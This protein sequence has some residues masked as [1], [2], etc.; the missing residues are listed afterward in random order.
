M[1]NPLYVGIL[2][3]SISNNEP[4]R[5]SF[6]NGCGVKLKVGREEY[7]YFCE[8]CFNGSSVEKLLVQLSKV[9]RSNSKLS[10]FNGLLMEKCFMGGIDISDISKLVSEV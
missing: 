2:Y 9:K 4:T 7:L 1:D 6:C 10:V 3:S 5:D 8:E